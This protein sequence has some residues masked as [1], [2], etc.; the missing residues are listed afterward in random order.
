MILIGKTNNIRRQMAA[1]SV[2]DTKMEQLNSIYTILISLAFVHNQQ[3]LMTLQSV[4]LS[5]YVPDG[6]SV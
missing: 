1:L 2:I 4:Y 6:R 5:V 3:G